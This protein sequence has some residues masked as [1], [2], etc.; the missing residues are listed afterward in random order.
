[1]AMSWIS[2]LNMSPR[3]AS[4]AGSRRKYEYLEKK[5]TECVPIW[6]APT[7]CNRDFQQLLS[8]AAPNNQDIFPKH[9]FEYFF[10]TKTDFCMM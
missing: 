5:G 6:T 2:N 9:K 8:A 1:M 10:P 3:F 4:P 7:R